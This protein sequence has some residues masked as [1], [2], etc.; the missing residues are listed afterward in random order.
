MN[1]GLPVKSATDEARNRTFGPLYSRNAR[2]VIARGL[3]A[4]KSSNWLV[5]LSGFFEPV[6]FLI[7]M[8]VGL[9]AIVGPVQ[10]P[11]GGEISYAAYSL[12]RCWPS[13]R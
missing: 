5:M 13:P 12:R 11:G 10:G 7:S 2:A 6:L 9:G 1:T 3:L 4:T 8:G